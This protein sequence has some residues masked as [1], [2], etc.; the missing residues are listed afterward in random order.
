MIVTV[1]VVFEAVVGAVV[2]VVSVSVTSVS[3]ASVSLVVVADVVSVAGTGVDSTC[4]SLLISFGSP[5]LTTST[6]SSDVNE[7]ETTAGV[8]IESLL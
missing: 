1:F 2:S 5:G 7:K 6:S 4:V 8:S 3:V